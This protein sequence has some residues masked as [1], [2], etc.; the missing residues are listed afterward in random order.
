MGG[1]GGF[2][3][4]ASVT[5]AAVFAP[6]GWIEKVIS[7]NLKRVHECRCLVN[8]GI[9]VHTSMGTPVSSWNSR[10]FSSCENNVLV[11]ASTTP[12]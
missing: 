7:V 11:V 12:A 2:L 1:A 4:A 5:I 6:E 10:R 3:P 9:W 8:A